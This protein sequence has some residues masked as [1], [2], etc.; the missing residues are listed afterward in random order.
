MFLAIGFFMIITERWL[1]YLLSIFIGTFAKEG[2]VILL[3]L[4]F[5]VYFFSPNNKKFLIFFSGIIGM[6]LYGIAT[7]FTRSIFSSNV[8]YVWLPSMEA[9]LSNL[10]R[11]RTY[12]SVGLSFGIGWYL[13]NFCRF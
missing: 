6:G 4:P 13:R 10:Y 3:P 5:V 11:I 2:I 8:N 7:Y 9:F 12:L 1:L